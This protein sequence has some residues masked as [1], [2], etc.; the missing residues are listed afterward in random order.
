MN[1]E[2]V[3]PPKQKP[4]GFYQLPPEEFQRRRAA[5]ELRGRKYR[6][7]A[8]T[9]ARVIDPVRGTIVVPHRSNTAAIFCAAE[10]WGCRWAEL[11]GAKVMRAEPGDVA[12][13]PPIFERSMKNGHADP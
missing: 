2:D 11:T 10:A 5:G 8:T 12:V 13:K 9:I 3:Q 7:S 1:W 6:W 4:T